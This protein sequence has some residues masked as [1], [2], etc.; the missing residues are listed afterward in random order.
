MQYGNIVLFG[1][2]TDQF[3]SAG[4]GDHHPRQCDIALQGTTQV[5]LLW[6]CAIDA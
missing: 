4:P 5:A 6:L 3:H 2:A 1:V